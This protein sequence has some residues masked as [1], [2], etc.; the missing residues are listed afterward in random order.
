MTFEERSTWIYAVV[1][2][3]TS[4][5][6][7]AVIAGRAGAVP[8]HDVAYVAPM[9]WTIGGGIAV[10]IAANVLVATAWREDCGKKDV[11]D[12]EIGRF[13][14]RVGQ[15]FICVSGV[16][17]LALSMAKV[18]H[19]WIA[20]VIYAGFV[21]STLLGAAMKLLAYRRGIPDC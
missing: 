11:R 13:G 2:L 12:V 6:Y 14:E 18:H 4:L 5:A 21:L 17:A 10:T 19:F 15:S 8:L 7:A 16:A 20:H 3:V 9:L 1:A